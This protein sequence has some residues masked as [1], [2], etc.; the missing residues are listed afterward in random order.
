[1]HRSAFNRSTKDIELITTRQFAF[2]YFFKQNNE[3]PCG[4]SGKEIIMKYFEKYK[5]L[6]LMLCF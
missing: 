6:D 1:M 5:S 3:A 2:T 4:M